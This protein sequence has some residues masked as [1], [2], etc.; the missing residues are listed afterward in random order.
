MLVKILGAL[1]LLSGIVF[2]M[3]IF[4]IEGWVSLTLFCAVLLF[5][6][7]LFIFSGEVL[8]FIDMFS[9]ILLFLS[10]FI[11][12]PVFLIWIS[13]FLLLAKGFVSFI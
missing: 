8:S 9:S 3:M 4:G 12:L 10:L 11:T 13:A 5:V 2:L 1:D 6:K 7:G